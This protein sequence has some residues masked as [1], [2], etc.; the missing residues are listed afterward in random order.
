MAHANKH[1]SSSIIIMEKKA[2]MPSID[3]WHIYNELS[4]FI[5]IVYLVK[6]VYPIYHGLL[7]VCIITGDE[8]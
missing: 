5:I 3:I 1:K 8:R 6:D 7:F 2:D 4:I